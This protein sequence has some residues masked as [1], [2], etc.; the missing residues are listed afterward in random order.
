MHVTRR[1]DVPRGLS[2][3]ELGDVRAE[4]Q[5]GGGRVA[6]ARSLRL[7]QESSRDFA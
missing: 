1:K 2:S 7:A 3:E 5:G 4:Q 6:A